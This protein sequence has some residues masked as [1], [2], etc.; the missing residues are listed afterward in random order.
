MP[1][2]AMRTSAGAAAVALFALGSSSPM[3]GGAGDGA[4]RLSFSGPDQAAALFALEVA[5]SFVR[6]IPLIDP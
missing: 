6:Q 4:G 5:S 1:R 3:I 2:V